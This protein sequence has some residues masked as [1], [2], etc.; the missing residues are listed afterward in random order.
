GLD[1]ADAVDGQGEEG[2]GEFGFELVAAL[3]ADVAAVGGGG[4]VGVLL[5]ELG[6]VLAL[7]GTLLDLVGEILQALFLGFGLVL[8]A[9]ED[10][11]ERDLVG[12]D[13]VGLVGVVI[14]GDL[15]GGGGGHARGDVLL[16]H[17]P[18]EDL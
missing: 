8:G 12:A 2:V 13:E 16:D 9:D 3:E 4:G 15:L 5:R 14:I 17:L 10:F 11:T 7:G 6:E 18:L 1:R